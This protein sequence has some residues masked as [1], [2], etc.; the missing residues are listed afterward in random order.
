VSGGRVGLDGEYIGCE[1]QQLSIGLGI[2]WA[3]LQAQ[4]GCVPLLLFF[5]FL[6]FVFVF[7]KYIVTYN[8]NIHGL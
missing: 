1:Q 3:S 4:T 8:I 5:C 6:F 2:H 7:N